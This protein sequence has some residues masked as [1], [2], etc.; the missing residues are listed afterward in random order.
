MNKYRAMVLGGMLAGSL[1]VSASPVL[2]QTWREVRRDENILNRDHEQLLQDRETLDRHLRYGASSWQI[3]RDQDRIREDEAN[4]RRDEAELRRD[5][6]ELSE[7]YW[8]RR[9]F[10]D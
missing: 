1:I 10:N 5:R 2:A 6:R 8:E 7:N 3:A 9:Y 4:I